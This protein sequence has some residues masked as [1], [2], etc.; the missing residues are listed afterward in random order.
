L[1]VSEPAE[2]GVGVVVKIGDVAPWMV[3]FF[4]VKGG[5]DRVINAGGGILSVGGIAHIIDDHI[6]HEIH[7]APVN[8]IRQSMEV[9][10]GAKVLVDGIEVGGPVAVISF[11]ILGVALPICGDGSM[12]PRHVPPQY[13]PFFKSHGASVEPSVLAKRSVMIWYMERDFHSS[14]VAAIVKLERER[15]RKREVKR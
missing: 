15:E 8:F 11:S 6:D 9:V 7:A 5:Q 3:V 13:G 4:I 2:L 10:L 1:V 14:V 12:M